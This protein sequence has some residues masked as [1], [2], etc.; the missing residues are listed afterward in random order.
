MRQRRVE[1]KPY[2]SEGLMTIRPD[3]CIHGGEVSCCSSSGDSYCGGYEGYEE[4]ED[5]KKWVIC[6]EEA[7]N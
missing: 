7:P 3:G 6:G 2:G 5:G 4:T 1:V